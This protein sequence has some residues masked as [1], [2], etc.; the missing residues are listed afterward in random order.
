VDR[1]R[2]GLPSP[3][4]QTQ[5]TIYNLIQ[6]SINAGRAATTISPQTALNWQNL[7]SIY[8]SLIGFG[9]NAD[10]F[11]VLTNQQAIALDPNNPQEYINLGGIYYQLNLLDKAIEQFQ[12]ATNL[13]PDFANGYYNLAH[14]YE[15]KGDLKTALTYLQTVQTL[16]KNDKTNA[17]KVASE[18]KDLELGIAK[19]NT[20]NQ[21]QG[22]LPVQN[23][24][25]IIPAPT[26]TTSAQ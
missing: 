11:A 26:A 10:S 6:Q 19:T 16:V 8:R 7:S 13:K 4:A 17:D 25:V 20:L 1:G 2:I 15:Q 23:P 18:I 24:P 12:I 3:S 5:Q 21:Q 22:N 9:K 14:S